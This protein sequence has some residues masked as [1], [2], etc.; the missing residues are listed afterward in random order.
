[1]EMFRIAHLLLQR[2][3]RQQP[4]NLTA[5]NIQNISLREAV[6]TLMMKCMSLP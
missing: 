1:M 4:F 3:S 6:L 5:A 2:H